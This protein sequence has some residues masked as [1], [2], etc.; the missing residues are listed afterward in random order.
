[1]LAPGDELP[2]ACYACFLLD[3]EKYL[4]DHA[5]KPIPVAL[6]LRPYPLYAPHAIPRI[7]LHLVLGVGG[8]VLILL[9]HEPIFIF[10]IRSRGFSDIA[11][12]PLLH[13]GKRFNRWIGALSTALFGSAG[14]GDFTGCSP[15]MPNARI[16]IGALPEFKKPHKGFRDGLCRKPLLQRRAGRSRQRQVGCS[17]SRVRPAADRLLARANKRLGAAPLLAAPLQAAFLQSPG[18]ENYNNGPAAIRHDV[19]PEGIAGA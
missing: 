18:M 13:L 1:M 9:I 6:H 8:R 10:G 5:D 19:R 17:G 7:I 2:K 3:P 4:P 16:G 11:K 14:G 12:S 15:A